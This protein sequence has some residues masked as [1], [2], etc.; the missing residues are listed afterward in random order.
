MKTMESTALAL[1]ADVQRLVSL[2]QDKQ[3]NVCSM[4]WAGHMAA[5]AREE[6]QVKKATKYIFGPLIDAQP[7]NPDTVL[8]TLTLVEDFTSKYGQ[9][10]IYLVADMQL[11]KI[12]KQIQRSNPL[13]W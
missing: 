5:R 6:K 1:E 4:E 12:V 8:T 3:D 9:K 13:R 11:F 7:T 2:I 10:Y